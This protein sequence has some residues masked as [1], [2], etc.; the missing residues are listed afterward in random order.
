MNRA[1]SEWIAPGSHGLVDYPQN[2]AEM[3]RILRS[4]LKTVSVPKPTVALA[5]P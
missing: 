4:H 2:I 3:K 5:A 1:Q